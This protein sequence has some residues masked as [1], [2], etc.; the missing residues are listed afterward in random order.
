MNW[1][2][3]EIYDSHDPRKQLQR[4]L[5]IG[6]IVFAVLYVPG[7]FFSLWRAK[8][9]GFGVGTIVQILSAVSLIMLLALLR[10]LKFEL[11]FALGIGCVLLFGFAG[12]ITWGLM[13]QGLLTILFAV[14]VGTLVGSFRQGIY[15]AVGSFLAIAATGAAI[16]LKWLPLNFP[17]EDYARSPVA[18]AIAL[19]TIGGLMA[20]LVAMVGR[21][22]ASWLQVMEHVQSSE[23]RLRLSWETSPDY[24]S[25]S[26]LRD[27]LMVDVNRGFTE[28]TGYSSDD[29]IGRVSLDFNLWVD[30]SDREKWVEELTKHGRVRDFETM[31][32]RKDG[33]TRTVAISAGL[34]SL[35]GEPHIFAIV[36]DIEDAKRAER[37]IRESE[38]K[39]RLLAENVTDVIFTTDL[40]LR[41]TYMSPSIKIMSGWTPSE[42]LGL[43][44]SDFLPPGDLEMVSQKLRD[45]LASQPTPGYDPSRPI[46]L[47]L[48][49]YRKD[50]SI[51]WAEVLA[52]FLLDAEGNPDGVIGVTR[53]I[54]ARKRTEQAMRSIVE[55]V[56]GETGDRFFESSVIQ[57]AN[58]LEADYTLIGEVTQKDHA[59]SV[60]TL[61]FSAGG[62]LQKNFEYKLEGAPCEEVAHKRI[63][64]YRKGV[65]DLF[66]RDQ[67]LAEMNIEAY[68]GVCL[69][70]SRNEPTGIMVA[71][72]KKPLDEAEFAEAV[73]RIFASRAAAEIERRK[74]SEDLQRL[75]VAVEHAGETI[76]ITDPKAR[77]LYVNSAFEKTTG[78][79]K[80]EALGETPDLIASRKQSRKF[81]E[82][83]WNTLRS[84]GVWRGRFTSKKKDGTLYEETVTISPITD[85]A[86]AIVSLVMVGRDV[87]AET[88]LQKQLQQA[89]KMEAVGTLAGGIA[90]DF[91]NLLQIM[92]GYT[93]LLLATEGPID[94]DRSMTMALRRAVKDGADLV[95]RILTFSRKGESKIRP[96]DLNAEIRRVEALLR[97][98]LPK[99]IQIDMV[100]AGDLR[101]IDGDPAQIEQAILNL[102]INAQHAMPDGGQLLI[103]T[104]NISLTEEY[105]KTH[106]GIKPGRYV[107]LKVSDTGAG[108]A[109]EVL[110]R[111]FEPFF[112]TKQDGQGTGLGLSMVHG[113]VSQHG[114]HVRCYSEPG[115]GTSFNIYLPV[116]ESELS[117]DPRLTR[118]MPTFGTE[119]VLLVDDDERVRL[120][121]SRMIE[122]G[123]YKALTAESGEEA[124]E[125]YERLREEISLV[126]LDVMM[127]GMGGRRCLEKLLELDPG[128]KVLLASGYSAT[129]VGKNVQWGAAKGFI[130]KPYDLKE[131]LF[132]IRKALDK[133]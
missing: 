40:D 126:V 84:G 124:V 34:M 88:M 13:G 47:E 89:Q 62:E 23:E 66:P 36:K 4:Q 109:P 24:V 67:M 73:L 43:K 107:L 33:E 110:D 18:W 14:Y 86:G 38:K 125:T 127:P 92:L 105:F 75:F 98:T 17:I 95:S 39:Y 122:M 91:N 87:T 78:Y 49:Q 80:E 50:G 129:Q 10:R 41:V 85:D 25:V 2:N 48:R 54:T 74:S 106:L 64:S 29:V 9:F 19:A 45:E 61:A 101:T 30:P 102:G 97:R 72:Y 108:I 70:D 123:G 94:P 21:W 58:I 82:D 51:F 57:F 27:G 96:I 83:L 81:Y 111:I 31:F 20:I 35:S 93:E 79:A 63:C 133:G 59:P 76:M 120:M 118:E 32:R 8:E 132:A 103:E 44:A 53:D 121:G 6:G 5:E 90:H 128:A 112:T 100:L 22:K 26:R 60:K 52:R 3:L 115:A 65:A 1:K 15:L 117:D 99:M 116:S 11:L 131:I 114:G 56:S 37:A 28:M 69:Y 71:M 113:I 42:A 7:V 55:G 12:L 130:N 46:A 119:T 68:V 104:R 77:I 16:V